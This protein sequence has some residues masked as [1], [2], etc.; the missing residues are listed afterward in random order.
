MA[1][2]SSRENGSRASGLP[3]RMSSS[4]CT[5]RGAE[6]DLELGAGGSLDGPARR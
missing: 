2:A 1:L 3:P 5:A 4:R 6:Y